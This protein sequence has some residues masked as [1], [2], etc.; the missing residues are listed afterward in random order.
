MYTMHSNIVFQSFINTNININLSEQSKLK[1]ET[2]E[3]HVELDITRT[4]Q[5]VLSFYTKCVSNHEILR[6]FHQIIVD[7]NVV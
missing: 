7:Q 3:I 5:W 4:P 1:L 2:Y 6:Y